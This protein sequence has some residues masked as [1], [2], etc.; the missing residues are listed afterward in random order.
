MS[1]TFQKLLLLLPIHLL[2]A[3]ASAR[4]V[5]VSTILIFG[6]ST[7]DPGNNNY[8]QTTFK[9]NFPPYGKDFMYHIPTGRFS[10]GRLTND[11]IAKYLGVKEYVPPYLDP[12]L[13]IEELKTGVSFASAGSGFD[14]LTPSISNVIPL[15]EQLE[16]LKEYK[17]NLEA[18]I[19]KYKTN[20]LIN[21]ALFL[22]SAGTNDFVL[23][24]FTLPIR[25][26]NY[27]IPAYMNFVLQKTR[28][29]LQG[30]IDQG[31]RR[32]GVVGLPPM[33][34]LPIV[35]TR[36]SNDPI[37][38]RD[39]ISKFSSIAREYNY[40]LRNELDHMQRRLQTAGFRIAYMNAY[41]PLEDMTLGRKYD[42][43]EV[44]NGCCGTGLLE[45]SFLC[46]IKCPVC[47]DADEYV[48]W[49]SIHPSERSYYIIF[50]ALRPTIDYL[51]RR[52][53]Y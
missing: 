26:S 17:M 30:L 43:E 13:S 48:F 4:D 36:Y 29:F 34:C 10:N 21:N 33:G 44:S 35:I 27:T 22:V 50:Q 52:H 31:A 14:P 23:N 5:S 53:N 7:V 46:N 42:F 38:E 1:F 40:M 6:D 51:V 2:V 32:I 24:Y 45:A 47:E 25:R 8:I 49:D 11:F 19:G 18:A 37:L 15:S 3:L 20:R 28:Q 12:T 39:C 41:R 9:S 16:Y